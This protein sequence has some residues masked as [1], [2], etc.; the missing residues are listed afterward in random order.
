MTKYCPIEGSSLTTIYIR[1]CF[2]W[3][4]KYK[5]RMLLTAIRTIG[6]KEPSL[7]PPSVPKEYGDI[8]GYI[9]TF[10]SEL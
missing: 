7:G 9:Y 3:R 8:I 5:Y 6:F 10:K 2:R 1:R 4:I